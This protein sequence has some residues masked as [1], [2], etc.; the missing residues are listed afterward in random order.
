[1]LWNVWAQVNLLEL[2]DKVRKLERHAG[3]DEEAPKTAPKAANNS[4]TPAMP[5]A[6]AAP[7]AAQMVVP[8]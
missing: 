3:V 1:L 8:E 7:L 5:A 2:Q 4:A 6:D